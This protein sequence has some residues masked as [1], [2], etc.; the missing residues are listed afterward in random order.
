MADA[1]KNS[2]RTKATRSP[3]TSETLIEPSPIVSSRSAADKKSAFSKTLPS[4]SGRSTKASP[5]LLSSID[6]SQNSDFNARS[7]FHQYSNFANSNVHPEFYRASLTAAINSTKLLEKVAEKLTPEAMENLGF[8]EKDLLYP[9]DEDLAKI[10]PKKKLQEIA[11]IKLTEDVDERRAQLEEEKL[12]L[13][14][15]QTD[16]HKQALFGIHQKKNSPPSKNSPHSQNSPN[17]KNSPNSNNSP[18]FKNSSISHDSPRNTNSLGSRCSKSYSDTGNTFPILKTEEI[19]EQATPA[20]E[21]AN[22]HAS[23]SAIINFS[24]FPSSFANTVNPASSLKPTVTCGKLA[25]PPKAQFALTVDHRFKEHRSSFNSIGDD[26]LTPQSR[27]KMT[28]GNK[29]VPTQNMKRFS[30]V[31]VK[32]IQALSAFNSLSDMVPMESN[33]NNTQNQIMS[34]NSVLKKQLIGNKANLSDISVRRNSQFMGNFNN[35]Q[36]YSNKYNLFNSANSSP[37][38]CKVDINKIAKDIDQN[39]KKSKN[40]KFDIDSHVDEMIQEDDILNGSRQEF[41]KVE[42]VKKKHKK[43]LEKVIFMSLYSQYQKDKALEAIERHTNHINKTQTLAKTGNDQRETKMKIIEEHRFD[44]LNEKIQKNQEKIEKCNERTINA[45]VN[46]MI[47]AQSIQN[48]YDDRILRAQENHEKYIQEKK[49]KRE[50]EF[51]IREERRNKGIIEHEEKLLEFQINFHEKQKQKKV[52]QVNSLNSIQI[53]KEI[54]RNEH[55][56]K[57]LEK[58]AAMYRILGD[59]EE[60]REEKLKMNQGKFERQQKCYQ[61]RNRI[62]QERKKQIKEKEELRMRKADH[63]LLVEQP[64]EYRQYLIKKQKEEDEARDR[65]EQMRIEKE[66]RVKEENELYF[67]RDWLRSKNMAEKLKEK[68]ETIETK[69]FEEKLKHITASDNR[70]I[71]QRK[72]DNALRKKLDKRVDNSTEKKTCKLIINEMRRLQIQEDEDLAE[73]MEIEF[74]R[75]M[76]LAKTDFGELGRLAAD[77]DVD[78]DRINEE[79]M[80]PRLRRTQ[81][82]V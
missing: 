66:E 26:D 28:P 40:T 74:R 73:Q 4:R 68:Q 81:T 18:N 57:R 10:S 29:L 62:Q 23:N 46:Q 48:R 71:Q 31:N 72:K 38:S 49:E 37:G 53:Q 35:S 43:E 16:L 34:R 58:E 15:I 3:N 5:S 52:R 12:R 80:N 44:R 8:V 36:N 78:I 47:Y 39:L 64:E 17:S 27:A 25:S 22:I 75:R 76:K 51:K 24:P 20:S 11:R 79:A 9:S 33:L 63:Y 50:N 69:H 70:Q 32:N 82:I 13:A 45:Y 21:T 67:A 42:K 55:N 59:K 41:S 19:I 60:L 61:E 1:R 14:K 54:K 65:I 56:N 2:L 6:N 30:S 7:N 77:Y